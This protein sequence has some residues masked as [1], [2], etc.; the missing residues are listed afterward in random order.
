MLTNRGWWLLFIATV[1]TLMGTAV[2]FARGPFIALLGL[3]LAIWVLFIG[4]GFVWAVRQ[5][6]S[7]LEIEREW[8]DERG[9][10]ATLWLNRTFTVV[11]RVRTRSRWSTPWVVIDDRLPVGATLVAGQSHGTFQWRRNEWVEWRYSIRCQAAGRMRFEGLRLRFA[12]AQGFYFFETFLREP[13]NI[14]VLPSLTEAELIQRDV[15]RQNIL[16][17]PGVHRLRQSGSGSELL[18]LRDYR[19]GDS[20]KLI[21]WKVSARKDKLITKEFESDVPVRCTL[22]LDGS[23]AVRLGPP[24]ET[25]LSRSIQIAAGL[26]EAILARRDPIGLLLFDETTTDYLE[27]ARG[28][29]HLLEI[30]RRLGE[31]GLRPPATPNPDLALVGPLAEALMYEIFPDLLERSVNRFSI[32]SAIW[33]PRPEYLRNLTLGDAVFPWRRRFSPRAWREEARRKRLA[34]VL[35]CAES[36]PLGGGALLA[37]DDRRLAL[38]M[39]QFLSRHQIWY[40]VP[41]LD[42]QGRHRFLH[43]EKIEIVASAMLRAVRRGRDNELF[44]LL[45]HLLGLREHLEPLRKVIRVALGRHHRV[46]VIVPWPAEVP[47]P[48]SSRAQ[49]SQLL[50][51]DAW[52]RQEVAAWYRGEF[53]ELRRDLARLGVTVVPARAEEAVPLILE[54]MEQL[55]VGGIRR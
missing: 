38:T 14:L 36:L 13:R 22:V 52:L 43:P 45:V 46:V 4:A 33:S 42:D 37:E 21:A 9:P 50:S 39:Q 20:P 35:T 27:P 16:L 3:S 53:E 10:V 51:W 25:A 26:A 31:I 7:R 48:D 44:I 19:P 54:R 18:D 17:P 5:T 15:K 8:R 34:A 30:L 24:G 6:L 28:R 29:R 23:S 12:D 32:W 11:V 55:R 49:S 2:S 1:I 40:P 41:V 47:F